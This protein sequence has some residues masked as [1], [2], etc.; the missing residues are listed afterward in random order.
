LHGVIV[1]AD[2][3]QQVEKTA[4]ADALETEL[5][6]TK[7]AQQKAR[8]AALIQQAEDDGKLDADLRAWAEVAPADALDGYLRV[9]KPTAKTALL[10]SLEASGKLTPGLREWA[11]KLPMRAL[12][13]YAAKAP[14]LIPQSE[15]QPPPDAPDTGLP[16]DVAAAVA[17]A[18]KDGWKA[19]SA[20]EKHAVTAHSRPL[21][22][23]LRGESR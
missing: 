4:Q 5:R 10:E 14:A 13:E 19:L 12:E 17:K 11:S 8:H 2:D 22:D 16:A 1:K 20:G 6:E 7:S 18:R 9:A 15:H 3:Q 21:A 23:R